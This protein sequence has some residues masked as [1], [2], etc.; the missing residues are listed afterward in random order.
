[1]LY[2]PNLEKRLDEKSDLQLAPALSFVKNEGQRIAQD[3]EEYKA[4][5]QELAQSDFIKHMK[6]LQTN[7]IE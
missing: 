5:L 4:L 6:A 2:D 3:K 7:I 1:M